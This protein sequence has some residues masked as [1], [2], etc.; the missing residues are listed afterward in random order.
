MARTSTLLPRGARCSPAMHS[1]GKVGRSP[2]QVRGSGLVRWGLRPRGTAHG[3]LIHPL[4]CEVSQQQYDIAPAEQPSKP[5]TPLPCLPSPTERPAGMVDIRDL[6]AERAPGS[7]S[8]RMRDNG[9]SCTT[10]W[11]STAVPV[12]PLQLPTCVRLLPVTSHLGIEAIC[13]AVQ[14]GRTWTGP[15]CVQHLP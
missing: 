5:P 11:N 8:L 12:L 9:I 7:C 13:Q 10:T 15:R 2:R 4:C 6:I 3:R 14:P 1:L